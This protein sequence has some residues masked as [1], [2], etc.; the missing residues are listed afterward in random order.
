[1]FHQ[2]YKLIQNS[3]RS[4]PH[5]KNTTPTLR[6]TSESSSMSWPK[7][8]RSHPCGSHSLAASTF[9]FGGHVTI[10]LHQHSTS[11]LFVWAI[12]IGQFGSVS[13]CLHIVLTRTIEDIN[14]YIYIHIIYMGLW[15]W[16]IGFMLLHVF[17]F[18]AWAAFPFV[19]STKLLH[20][21][22]HRNLCELQ[23]WKN[24]FR[25]SEIEA[26]LYSIVDS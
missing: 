1:M 7:A 23:G 9:F 3:D 15:A 18:D 8:L 4:F 22:E 2:N 26:D 5:P 21:W 17:F 13:N 6:C 24:P 10:R 20:W 11:L 19:E 25:I 14:I 16:F 12:F